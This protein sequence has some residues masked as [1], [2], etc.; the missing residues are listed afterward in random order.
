MRLAD[1]VFLSLRSAFGAGLPSVL[2]ILAIFVATFTAGTIF[3]VSRA[4]SGFVEEQLSRIGLGGI[5]VYTAEPIRD[6]DRVWAC[7]AEIPQ[8]EAVMPLAMTSGTIRSRD[9]QQSAMFFGV[10]ADVTRVYDL[11]LLCGR[12]FTP[13][14][15][16]AGESV[17][18]VDDGLAQAL[19]R[20]INIVGKELRI[21]VQGRF[22]TARVIG[23]YRSQKQ[24]LEAAA[25]V[26]I[27][28][29]LYLPLRTLG[30]LSDGI[31]TDKIAFSCIDGTD[32]ELVAQSA[33][34]MLNRQ[35]EQNF[36]YENL[37]D[38]CQLI[39]D[40]TDTAGGAILTIGMTAV[41]VGGLGLMI[42]MLSAVDRRRQII[43][44]YMALGTPGSTVIGLLL[45]E[46]VELCLVGGSLGSI[47]SLVVMQYAAELL[48]LEI[49]SGVMLFVVLFSGVLGGLFGILP[50]VRAASMDPIQALTE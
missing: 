36:R 28:E 8:V 22:L 1:K 13:S 26:K 38:Y 44:I 35:G 12:S 9:E 33:V 5:T 20:R 21:S 30:Q 46:S 2:C 29:I 34:Q 6:L 11:E 31:A 43:G 41:L 39:S 45:L 15:L 4:A 49:E 23:V 14:E 40:V 16:A 37:S 19:Y 10:G 24:G 42:A 32:P 47:L 7:L 50:A 17:V 3:H 27:P 25:G 48:P 18:L